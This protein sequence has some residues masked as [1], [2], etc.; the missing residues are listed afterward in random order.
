MYNMQISVKRVKDN[1]AFFSVSGDAL[2]LLR[3]HLSTWG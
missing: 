3:Y 1:D 2:Y